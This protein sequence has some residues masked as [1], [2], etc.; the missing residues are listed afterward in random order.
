MKQPP[1]PMT[2]FPSRTLTIVTTNNV[3]SIPTAE[4]TAGI[5]NDQP[6]IAMLVSCEDQAVRFTFGDATPDI[7]TSAGHIMLAQEVFLRIEN[8]YA[9]RTFQFCSA[10]TDFPAFLHI[11]LEFER[12][13]V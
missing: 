6:V 1:L 3:D 8:P 7:A 13:V 9:I 2:G 5:N 4:L 10:N 11:T 12:S